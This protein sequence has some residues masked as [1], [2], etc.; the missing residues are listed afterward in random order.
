MTPSRL[1]VASCLACLSMVSPADAGQ[2]PAA[3]LIAPTLSGTFQTGPP[4]D[5]VAGRTGTAVIRG[6]V[7]AAD[8]GRPLRRASV[9]V[10][11]S[12][13]AAPGSGRTTITNADGRYEIRDLPAGR[14]TLTVQRNG[15][16][17]LS[18][19]QRRP[20]E[21]GRPLDIR[22]K[23]MLDNVDMTLPRMGVISGRILD[24]VGEPIAGVN[25]V[26]M[27]QE[28]FEGRRRLVPVAGPASRSTDDIG[29]YRVPG[30]APGTY[31]VMARAPATWTVSEGGVDTVMS[32]GQTYY[33]TT[34]SVR[35]TRPIT[36][37]VGQEITGT[38]FSLIPARAVSVSGML[39]DAR[40]QP[41]AGGQVRLSQE[42]RGPNGGAVFMTAAP[43]VTTTSNGAFRLPNVS[44][45]DYTLRA[46]GTT[47]I[48]GVAMQESTTTTVTVASVDLDNL[49]LTASSGWSLT[50]R[51]TDESGTPP[52]FPRERIRVIG[53]TVGVE[54]NFATTTV[55]REDWTFDMTALCGP[56]RI[57]ASL[58]DGWVVKSIVH[59]GRDITDAPLKAG[60]GDALSGATIIIARAATVTGQLTDDRGA[61]LPDG[62]IIV[63]AA[64][65][66][67]W[68]EDSRFT[69]T[70]RPDQQG[71][72]QISGLPAGEYLAVALG[73][74][75]DRMWNDP[76][77]L[78][79]IRRYAQR[80]RL[81]EAES[82]SVPLRLATP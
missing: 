81:L 6:R 28:Y 44:P 16:L 75:E 26:V 58:P 8:T 46:S 33:P 48:N 45:G 27:R 7:F 5:A 56:S 61:P 77:Y 23:Q 53:R 3:V 35:E 19:G 49:I 37:G 14:Y 80:F 20:F 69:R 54:T 34:S 50:G 79:S 67:K 42:L 12:S 82:L 70:A 63:F 36:V 74:V 22:D 4:R 11:T 21:P 66:E 68:F 55:V 64:E 38:D 59:D 73:Y 39:L 57:L 25:V 29:Q 17:Q 15:Y 1:L 18:Y 30:L 41:L 24:E 60:S 72:Y 71:R 43:Q 2:Q 10:T 62:T 78:E 13:Q 51:V 65:A 47:N 40:G 76:D 31:F 9:T 32:Y 52:A